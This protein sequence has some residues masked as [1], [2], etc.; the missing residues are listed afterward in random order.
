[1]V[2]EVRRVPL[3]FDAFLLYAIMLLVVSFILYLL[4]LSFPLYFPVF[5]QNQGL[6]QTGIVG[7]LVVIAITII[8]SIEILIR[9]Q[10][11]IKKT[12]VLKS[13]PINIPRYGTR[14]AYLHADSIDRLLLELLQYTGGNFEAIPNMLQSEGMGGEISSIEQRFAKLALLGLVSVQ[15]TRVSGRIYLTSRGLDALN[16][17][18]T[19][20][21]SNIPSGIW[22]YIFRMKL[23]IIEENWDGVVISMSQALELILN[24]RLDEAKRNSPEKW[25]EVTTKTPKFED[26]KLGIGTLIGALCAMAVF[27]HGSFEERLLNDLNELRNKIHPQTDDTETQPFRANIAARIDLYFDII[28]QRWYNS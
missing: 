11:I 1:M 15:R 17:P 23:N 27:E 5:V 25:R 22:E 12:M 3:K 14:P 19:L 4:T 18:A 13:Q 7:S 24:D 10:R 26:T 21:I 20:F 2:L 16:A 9:R 6:I 8:P 28:L